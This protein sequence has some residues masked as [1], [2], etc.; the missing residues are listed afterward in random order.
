MFGGGEEYMISEI[1]IFGEVELIGI[2]VLMGNF[3][4]VFLIV[5]IEQVFLMILGLV[6]EKDLRFLEGV[7][8][9][10]VEIVNEYELYFCVWEWGLGIIQVCG[11]GVCVVVVVFVLNG[12]LE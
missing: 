4:I 3:Y 9:E 2:V 6:I 12:V 7:N 8:V 5:D 10:F 11:I 1:M